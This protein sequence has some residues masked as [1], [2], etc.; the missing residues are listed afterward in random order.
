PHN[1]APALRRPPLSRP[2]PPRQRPD[3]KPPLALLPRQ[4]PHR[5]RLRRRLLPYSHRRVG[6]LGRRELWHKLGHP[7]H[8]PR[9]GCYPVGRHL[10]LCLPAGRRYGSGDRRRIMLR[11]GVLRLDLLGH[12]ALRLARGR[13]VGVCVARA[14]RVDEEGGSCV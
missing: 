6:R 4:R 1:P 3:P 13:H 9:R 7:G 10:R 14:G 11:Q 8:D 2:T 12:G 5:R